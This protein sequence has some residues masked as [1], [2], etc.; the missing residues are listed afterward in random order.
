M[1]LKIM[2]QSKNKLKFKVEGE[3]HT[4]CNV[5]RK[6]LWNDQHIKVS[7][8]HI[9]HPMLGQPL[10]VVETDGKETP[11]SALTKAVTRLKTKNKELKTQIQKLK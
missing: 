5:L 4:F 6:E 10:F 8:Y 2:E 9:E 7:G 3:D 1:E 11:K